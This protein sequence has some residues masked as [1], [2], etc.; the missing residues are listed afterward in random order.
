[1][2]ATSHPFTFRSQPSLGPLRHH[3]VVRR[4][5]ERARLLLL[6]NDLAPSQI[7]LEAGFSHQTHMGPM[8]PSPLRRAAVGP[9]PPRSAPE[10]VLGPVANACFRP[11]S[12]LLPSSCWLLEG[13]HRASACPGSRR[14]ATFQGGEDGQPAMTPCFS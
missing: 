8:A 12:C 14:F 2:V 10:S 9:S 3:Y 7:A 1:L 6:A 4:R 13:E 5:S 11:Q